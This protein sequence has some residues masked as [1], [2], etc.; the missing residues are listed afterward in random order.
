MRGVYRIAPPSPAVGMA[1]VVSTWDHDWSD[2]WPRSFRP[3]ITIAYGKVGTTHTEIIAPP[4]PEDLGHPSRLGPH[5]ST[6]PYL[7]VRKKEP[8]RT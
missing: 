1:R 2:G 4:S 6:V 3:G 5:I 7:R 8:P